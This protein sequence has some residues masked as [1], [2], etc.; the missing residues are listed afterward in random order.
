MSKLACITEHEL[1]CFVYFVCTQC[2]LACTGKK[3][4]KK[5]NIIVKKG[6]KSHKTKMNGRI[7]KNMPKLEEKQ[8]ILR[9][10]NI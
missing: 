2:V 3:R 1:M 10:K 4:K 5:N 7:K 9:K 6:R 8:Q